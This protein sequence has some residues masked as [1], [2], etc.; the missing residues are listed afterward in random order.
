MP[1]AIEL[2]H[3]EKKF[4][5]KSCTFY[6]KTRSTVP[7]ALAHCALAWNPEQSCKDE[8]IDGTMNAIPRNQALV[9][10]GVPA[11]KM[12]AIQDSLSKRGLCR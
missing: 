4:S 11:A 1:R 6:I 7:R 10:K 3:R 8:G 2:L 12:H 9:V 5:M